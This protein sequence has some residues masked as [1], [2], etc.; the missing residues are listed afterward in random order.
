[1]RTFPRAKNEGELLAH[2]LCFPR[3]GMA[4]LASALISASLGQAAGA[5]D[6]GVAIVKD[7]PFYENSLAQA[8]AF[9]SMQDRTAGGFG[10]A[11]SYLFFRGTRAIASKQAEQ[12]LYVFDPSEL[13]VA[14]ISSERQAEL[15]LARLRKAARLNAKVEEF[16]QPFINRVEAAKNSF[17]RGAG[18]RASV[19]ASPAPTPSEPDQ[20]DASPV[21]LP[22]RLTVGGATY[23]NPRYR[24][25]DDSRLNF[26]H[27]TGVASV[28]IISLPPD[29]QKSL[30]FDPAKAVAAEAE[31]AKRRQ[32][33]AESRERRGAAAAEEQAARE[34]GASEAP[35]VTSSDD[36]GTRGEKTTIEGA[37]V[38]EQGVEFGIIVV[39]ESAISTPEAASRTRA[40]FQLA[41]ADFR[42]IPLILA[43]QDS[44]GTFTYQGRRDIV[45][46][47]SSIDPSRIPWKRYTYSY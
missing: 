28:L 45:D 12:V 16:L 24:S 41:F 30:G 17:Q 1:M 7:K 27:D 13:S 37:L 23:T 47:L 10:T 8:F 14:E 22:A 20:E 43:S 35:A 11:G 2:R 29:I 9:T 36:E 34:A 46:F 26:S 44:S 42:G 25:H 38:R 4:L 5:S 40:G 3:A 33:A 32:D 6:L 15:T 31:A 18:K 21:K 39:K 19:A